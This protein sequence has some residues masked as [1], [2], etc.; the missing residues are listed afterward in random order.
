VRRHE[1]ALHFY[2]VAWRD[3]RFVAM[4]SKYPETVY[5]DLQEVADDKWPI[6]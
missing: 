4:P 3:F 5:R 6:S 2:M 1:Y